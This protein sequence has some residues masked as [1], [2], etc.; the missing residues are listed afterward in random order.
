MMDPGSDRLLLGFGHALTIDSA[1][2]IT[3]G[4]HINALPR[5]TSGITAFKAYTAESRHVT[6]VWTMISEAAVFEAVKTGRPLG[7]QEQITA[8]QLWDRVA[9]DMSEKPYKAIGVDLLTMLRRDLRRRWTGSSAQT[10]GYSGSA[11]SGGSTG[12]K[13]TRDC[14]PMPC[15]ARSQDRL[16]RS[17]RRSSRT[18]RLSQQSP[19]ISTNI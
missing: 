7:D 15:A 17:A 14:A 9:A 2:G 11:R 1:Q 6:Q 3:S 12:G 16:A 13:S 4:E 19:T 5:G 18:A 10:T 8:D